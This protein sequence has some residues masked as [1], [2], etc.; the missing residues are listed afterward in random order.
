VAGE[1]DH[2]LALAETA[3]DRSRWRVSPMTRRIRAARPEI[4]RLTAILY[5][6]EPVDPRGVAIARR[7]A[8]D[9]TGPVYDPRCG[10]SLVD[11][12]D[13][14]IAA[15]GPVSTPEMPYGASDDEHAH[16]PRGSSLG[17]AWRH[18]TT[19]QSGDAGRR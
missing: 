15:L 7:L 4:E 3:P 10:R 12:V 13:E 19:N 17:L 14:A 16:R 2:L 5:S 9:G 8:R 11:E 18:G 6:L 1:W